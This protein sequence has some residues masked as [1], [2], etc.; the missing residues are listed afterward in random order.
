MKS[1]LN[2]FHGQASIKREFSISNIIHNNNTKKTQSWQKYIL[3]IM[4][5]STKGTY[6]TNEQD[7]FKAV[8][9]TRSKWEVGR[10]EKEQHQQNTRNLENLK[11]LLSKDIEQAKERCYSLKKATNIMESE[12]IELI[13]RFELENSMALVTKGN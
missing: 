12:F 11:I 10:G 6:N 9:S 5:T 2:L 1:V 7:L 3:L 8:K 13:K 4:W